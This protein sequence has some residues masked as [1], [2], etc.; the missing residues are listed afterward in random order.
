MLVFLD[1][2]PQPELVHLLV[3][4]LGGQVF[5]QQKLFSHGRGEVLEG[6]GGGQALFFSGELGDPLQQHLDAQFQGAQVDAMGFGVF[7]VGRMLLGVHG[8]LADKGADIFLQ[9]RVFD[10][11]AHAAHAVDKELLPIGKQ[12]RQVVHELGHERVAAPPVFLAVGKTEIHSADGEAG[13]GGRGCAGRHGKVLGSKGRRRCATLIVM[14]WPAALKG[15]D[16]CSLLLD[17]QAIA[18]RSN[19]AKCAKNG[20]TFDGRKDGFSAG[21][22]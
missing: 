2:V 16:R 6:A 17:L 7:V 3:I 1:G 21:W 14:G 19:M 15:P 18:A 5:A 20:P 9:L 11:F 12:G 10:L 4:D 22:G 13:L 8:L